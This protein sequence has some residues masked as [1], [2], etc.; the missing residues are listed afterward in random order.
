[1]PAVD[2]DRLADLYDGL[3]AGG[4]DVPFFVRHA[5]AARGP[6]LELMA[7]TGRVSLPVLFAGVELTCL[8]GSAEMLAVLRRKL[9]ARG[10]TAEIV[11]QD[12]ASFQLERRFALI[13]IA[14]NSFSE[15]VG[16]DERRSLLERVHDHLVPGGRFLCTLQDPELRRR[17]PETDGERRMPF[18]APDGRRLVLVLRMTFDP[19]TLLGSGTERIEEAATGRVVADLP[20]RF[21]L[22]T[23]AGFRDLAEAAGFEVGS[24]TGGFGHRPYVPGETPQMVWALR[25]P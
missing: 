1:V 4:D 12:A 15:V 3:V 9:D 14:Y 21:R 8:D 16:D 6:V 18:T 22:T 2:Y 19:E 23:A 13:F 17:A 5:R 7:G 11:C 10:L 20:I 25:R 24:L